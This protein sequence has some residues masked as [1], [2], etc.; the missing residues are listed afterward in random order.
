MILRN[1][2][3]DTSTQE[4][5]DVCEKTASDF[6]VEVSVMRENREEWNQPVKEYLEALSLL[7]RRILFLLAESHDKREICE[8]LHITDSHYDNSYKRMMADERIKPLR[9]LAEGKNYA[10][11]E[12]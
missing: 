8:I 9:P 7:Q 10:V 11:I 4:G 12:R 5:R 6:R 3:L 2:T 1:V